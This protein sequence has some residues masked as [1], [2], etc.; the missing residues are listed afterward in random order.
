MIDQ[1]RLENSDQL[2]RIEWF[3]DG[4][5]YQMVQNRRELKKQKETTLIRDLIIQAND[6]GLISQ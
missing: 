2:G 6:S 5:V 3:S 4:L 1:Y